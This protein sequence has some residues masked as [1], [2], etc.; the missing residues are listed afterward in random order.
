MKRSKSKTKSNK[1]KTKIPKQ[2]KEIPFYTISRPDVLHYSLQEYC[3]TTLVKT[4][5]F[6]NNMYF[7]V[8]NITKEPMY[9]GGLHTLLKK[10]FYPDYDPNKKKF[11]KKSNTKSSTHVRGK[12]IDKQLL[13]FL[14]ERQDEVKRVLPE[15][16]AILNYFSLIGH[17]GQASQLPVKIP[18]ANK[19]TQCDYIT[20]SPDGYLYLWEIKSGGKNLE[21]EIPNDILKNINPKIIID[22]VVGKNGLPVK[23]VACTQKNIWQLQLHFT[24]K[25]LECAGLPIRE[26][27]VLQVSKNQFNDRVNVV[28]HE[29]PD[30]LDGILLNHIFD[31]K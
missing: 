19:L 7:Y 16:R 21:H 20:R 28:V 1:R 4:S 31:D 17:I 26:A 29:Q 11:S 3:R 15:T 5:K 13:L 2:I 12:V 22:E 18:V 14:D 9:C 6:V 10:Y 23:G 30:W 27:R 25:S 8:D 24:R